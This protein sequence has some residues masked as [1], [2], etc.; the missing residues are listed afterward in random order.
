MLERRGWTVVQVRHGSGAARQ[1]ASRPFDALVSD[2]DRDGNPNAGFD[3]LADLRERGYQGPAVFYTGRITP[4]RRERA[5]GLQASVTNSPDE[6][7]AELDH[8]ARHR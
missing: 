8:L 4:E 6:L 1:L 2:I 3:D 7:L 5:A